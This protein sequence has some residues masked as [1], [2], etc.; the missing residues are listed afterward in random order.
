MPLRFFIFPQL[1]FQRVEPAFQ[2]FELQLHRVRKIDLIEIDA[3]FAGEVPPR[4]AALFGF[5]SLALAV[6]AHS[7]ALAGRFTAIEPDDMPRNTHHR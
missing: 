7:D 6:V 3:L 2:L 4:T 5:N 1:R